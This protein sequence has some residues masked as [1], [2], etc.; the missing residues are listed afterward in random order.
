M[1]DAIKAGGKE[2]CIRE[3]TGLIPDAYFQEASWHGS[4]IMWMV[5]GSG[6]RTVNCCLERLIPG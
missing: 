5:Q 1:I 3:R 6:R 4:W 2:A